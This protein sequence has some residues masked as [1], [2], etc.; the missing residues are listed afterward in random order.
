MVGLMGG[1][2]WMA[3]LLCSAGMLPTANRL[4]KACQA[5]TSGTRRACVG[6][7]IVDTPTWVSRNTER[8]SS[9]VP[10]QSTLKAPC[11]ESLKPDKQPLLQPRCL[12]CEQA[13]P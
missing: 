7:Y 10:A 4:H 12:V 13:P 3:A 8:E 11:T 2:D 9:S 5:D 6:A 1:G